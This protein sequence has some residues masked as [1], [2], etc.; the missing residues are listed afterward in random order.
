MYR[1]FQSMKWST[2]HSVYAA[3]LALGF[4]AL[5]AD[6]LMAGNSPAQAARPRPAQTK[7]PRIA[8]AAA[9]GVLPGAHSPSLAQRLGELPSPAHAANMRDVFLASQEWT[10][11][12]AASDRPSSTQAFKQAHHLK[13][14]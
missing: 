8:P 6:R 4:T 9:H 3:V 11:A 10:G 1:P 2:K 12:S 7:T 14:G 13:G 5:L